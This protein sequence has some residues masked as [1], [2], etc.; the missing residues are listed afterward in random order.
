MNRRTFLKTSATA[1]AALPALAVAAEKNSVAP[2]S[3]NQT[4]TA[5]AAYYLNA[6][7]YTIVPA[8]VRADMEWM[9][10]IG[11]GYV[12]IGVL[13]QDLFAAYENHALIAEEA[14][15]VGMKMIAV[16]SRWAGLTAGAP[17]VPSL[18]TIL[19]PQTW[20]V[21]KKGTT[22][23]NPRV[24]GAISSIHHPDTLKFF[25]DTLTELYKQHPTMA[26]FIID[27]PKGF[28]VDK[29]K[30]A[31]D[32][33]GANAPVTAHLAATRDFFGRICA[34]AKQKWPDKLTFLFQQAHNGADELAAGAA[35]RHL[36]Y[37]GCD[38]RPWTLEDDKKMEG[39]GEGQESGKGKVLL[40]GR[41]ESFIKAARAVPGRKSFF[42][43]EN[44]NL[45]AS[46]IELMDRNYPAVLALKPD[47][48]AYY[49]YPR[50]VQEPDRA[51]AVIA[52]HVKKFTQGRS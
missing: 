52:K 24:S 12:C 3:V 35:V 30:M 44:H 47:M 34:F 13:E 5:I 37:Y 9:A 43:M 22:A 49:Y 45:R 2:R 1:T 11:T 29:S 21:N 38:G 18:F 41:G 17:K 23:V 20:M 40:S 32:A 10:A 7:M 4:S 42:L 50:N 39:S 27:E 26:G 14:H 36:D 28:Q 46:M 48:A 31:V 19:N 51:M 6:H 25:C 15:R 16:P 8:H 33:L